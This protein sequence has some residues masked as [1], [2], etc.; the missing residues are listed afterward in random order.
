MN[1]LFLRIDTT[2]SSK[3]NLLQKLTYHGFLIFWHTLHTYLYTPW[4]IKNVPLFWTITSV[5]LDGFQH[6]VYQRREE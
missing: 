5:F 6:F 3:V 1:E 4:A 2:C